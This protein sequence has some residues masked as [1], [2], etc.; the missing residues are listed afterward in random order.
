MRKSLFLAALVLVSVSC[1]AQKN[2]NIRK[3]KSMVNSETPDF[4]AARAQVEQG[5]A[6][7]PTA[8]NYY[9]AGY[10]G[11]RQVQLENYKFESG[12]EYDA[13]LAG[14][15]AA[16]S[17]NYWL[18]AD[19]LA[20]IP[21]LDK[22]G[23]E[24]VDQ[25]TRNN[26]AKKMIEYF[27]NKDLVKYGIFLN[28]QKD[29]A[30][31]FK[32]FKM[33][34][35]IPNLPMMQNDKLQK[36]LVRD[37][38]YNQYKYY[39]SLFAM[40]SELHEEAIPLL[41]S[42]KEGD[43]EAVSINQFLYQEYVNVNDT[44]KFVAQL[45]YAINRF[46]DEEW[47]MQN[48]VNYSV[49]AK[50]E[51]EAVEFLTKLIEANPTD[52]QYIVK[53]GVMNEMLERYDDALADF[54]KALSIDANSADAYAGKGRLFYNKAVKMNEDAKM[55]DDNR[56]YNKAMQEAN[57]VFR[58]SLPLFEKAHELDPSRRSFMETLKNLYARFRS[59]PDM[60]AK[61]DAISEKLNNL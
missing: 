6:A 1:L 44:P 46:P 50:Q 33:H 13:G 32:A 23:R 5:L 56:A 36:E 19:E 40:Q 57:D 37:S 18:K 31:A 22:K 51:A 14:P 27:K 53:R 38:I 12:Q 35:D 26:I 28:E 58:Q 54:E 52:L 24:V 8:E 41:E 49:S 9:W 10:I 43:F 2:P 60:Q 11:Y 16:E 7:E 21:T 30:G 15:A 39:C 59:E 34:I 47:F 3:A 45:H 61:Y 48:L 4:A 25:K 55:I 20:M 17:Y 42:I 29:Y